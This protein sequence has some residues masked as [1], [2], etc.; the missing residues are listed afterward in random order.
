MAA[1]LAAVFAAATP[2]TAACPVW[3]SPEEAAAFNRAQEPLDAAS[4]AAL[5]VPGS[6]NECWCPVVTYTHDAALLYDAP[7]VF[8]MRYEWLC[9]VGQMFPTR[10]EAEAYVSSGAITGLWEPEAP[11]ARGAWI[12]AAAFKRIGFVQIV[13]PARTK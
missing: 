6:D 12:P 4:S 8:R 2:A 10:P 3:A 11:A 5:A 9:N 13:H 1:A 7:S